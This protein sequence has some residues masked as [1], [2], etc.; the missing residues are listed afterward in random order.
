MQYHLEMM[1]WF[2]NLNFFQIFDLSTMELSLSKVVWMRGNEKDSF[3]DILQK[4][5][6][7]D[8]SFFQAKQKNV[9]YVRALSYRNWK[10]LNAGKSY[11]D[12]FRYLE[13]GSRYTITGLSISWVTFGKVLNQVHSSYVI[14][15]SIKCM[16]R[17]TNYTTI[18]IISNDVIV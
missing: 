8:A 14:V 11:F 4:Y 12:P 18:S 5:L 9:L 2:I 17:S 3:A 15:H 7:N 1:F 6:D 16:F 13:R 10:L